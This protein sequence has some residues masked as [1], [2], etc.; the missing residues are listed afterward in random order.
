MSL[1]VRLTLN[2]K[3]QLSKVSKRGN[4]MTRGISMTTQIMAEPKLINVRINY[5]KGRDDIIEPK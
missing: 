2:F 1:H 5:L 4:R 3:E